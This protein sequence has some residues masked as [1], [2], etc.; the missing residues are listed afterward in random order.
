M[1]H[2]KELNFFLAEDDL[3]SMAV[4]DPYELGV[5]WEGYSWPLGTAWYRH[6]FS[7]AARVRGE[8]SVAYTFPWYRGVADRMARVVP[9]ARLIFLVRHPLERAAS[10]HAQVHQWDH[11]ELAEALASDENIYVALGAYASMLRP[12]LERFSRERLLILRHED[13]LTKR[14]KTMRKTFGFLGVDPSFWSPKMEQLRN[15]SQA[16][17][18]LYQMAER[19]RASRGSA[20]LRRLPVRVKWGAERVLSWGAG[21]HTLPT[22]DPKLARS[23]LTRLEPD[24]AELEEMTGW[25]LDSW[26]LPPTVCHDGTVAVPSA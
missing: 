17:G 8:S 11:R 19:V 2:P 15:R 16:K 26:R 3:D 21:A 12:F 18:H 22:I 4:P 13:L 6:H 14:Q 24:I 7:P 20:S 25:D 23:V 5:L 9:D 1:S 10:H